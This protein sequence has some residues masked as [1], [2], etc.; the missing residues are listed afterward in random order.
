MAE[1][2]V[3]AGLGH[4][5]INVDGT[6]L[7]LPARSTQAG[8]TL[9]IW[10]LFANTSILTW[11]WGTGSQYGLTVLAC[12]RQ[13]TVA[14]ITAYVIKAG[15]LVQTWIRSTF[16]NI[17][18][19]VIAFKA[20]LASTPVSIHQ[21]V[22]SSPVLAWIRKTFIF[23]HFTVD[24]NPACITEALVSSEAPSTVSVDTGIAQALVHL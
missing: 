2:V 6:P 3:H 22:T 10:C 24:A 4:T 18:L 20:L 23:V 1:T 9:K 16:I 5:L 11:V 21:I 19:A 8:V 17:H 15:S 7:T 12:V 14:S 13:H